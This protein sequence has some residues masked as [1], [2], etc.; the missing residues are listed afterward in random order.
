MSRAPTF[1]QLLPSTLLVLAFPVLSAQVAPMAPTTLDGLYP[2]DRQAAAVASGFQV[3]PSASR[4]VM[5]LFYNSVYRSSVGVPAQWQGDIGAC[6][7]GQLSTDYQDSMQRRVNWFRA[8]AGVPAAITFDRSFSA[9]A[10]QAALMMAANGALS[11]TPP[12]SWKC[13]TPDGAQAAGNSV[14]FLGQSIYAIVDSYMSDPGEGN[15]FLGHRRWLMY[16]QTQVMGLGSIIPDSGATRANAIWVF[17]QNVRG[18]RPAVRDEFVAWPPKGYVPYNTVYPRWSLSYPAADFSGATVSM[19]RNGA[20]ISVKQEA[21]VNGHGENTLVWIPAPYTHSQNWAKPAADEAYQVTVNNVRV[22]GQPRSF[23][24]TVVVFD[25]QVKG[26]DHVP[27]TV[28]GASQIAAGQ[29][30]NYAFNPVPAADGYQWRQGRVSPYGTVN[31]AEN[32]L[33]EFVAT[34]SGGYSG[35]SA[36]RRAAGQGA[37]HLAHTQATDQT[38]TL[39]PTFLVGPGASLRFQSDLGYA[40]AHQA[41]IVELSA[42]EGLSWTTIYQ[43]A[44]TEQPEPGYS[45]KVIS[46]ADWADKTVS[47]RFRY[48]LNGNF[49]YPQAED[50]VGWFFD[51]V[52]LTN[53]QVAQF[54]APQATGTAGAFSFSGATA[55]SY[56]LQVR[57]LLFGGFAGEWSAAKTITVGSGGGTVLPFSNFQSSVVTPL[58]LTTAG[59]PGAQWSAKAAP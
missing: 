8:M 6:N 52:A 37:Y 44:G 7:A 22:N 50:N 2:S 53:V 30:L 40:T 39:K 10:Q 43:Q 4:E 55:G 45:L 31:G 9:K 56:L 26:A 32:G 11:H 29:S 54:E 17:D 49:Y 5:R 51:E 41:A 15:Y 57:P 25:P 58:K 59:Q 28:T 18:T 34:I 16:P 19:T 24:Y 36:T 47:V 12:T 20:A 33:G 46:L 48:Q 3:N 35:M 13:Y 42:D 38:L 27:Q 23:N 1:K 21:L 14:L